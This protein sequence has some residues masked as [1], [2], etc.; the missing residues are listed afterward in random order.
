ML[1]NYN[2]LNKKNTD[3]TTL[4]N[5]TLE[6]NGN[7]NQCIIDLRKGLTKYFIV[8]SKYSG[9]K[10]LLNLIKFCIPVGT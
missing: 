6:I 3:N 9:D 5:N 2:K 8:R 1:E 7:S 4:D 10:K